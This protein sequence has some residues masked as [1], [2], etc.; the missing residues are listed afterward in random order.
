MGKLVDHQLSDCRIK[1][2]DANDRIAELEARLAQYENGQG[3]DL[4][5]LDTPSPVESLKQLTRKAIQT[6]SKVNGK[7][8]EWYIFEHIDLA[9]KR[10]GQVTLFR[11]DIQELALANIKHG[12]DVAYQDAHDYNKQFTSPFHEYLITL[13]HYEL[14]SQ[15]LAL[16]AQIRETDKHRFLAE[17]EQAGIIDILSGN[18]AGLVAK[19]EK[20]EPSLLPTIL[21]IADDIEDHITAIRRAI[22][23][24]SDG[25]A[26]LIKLAVNGNETNERIMNILA[27]MKK[28]GRP[29]QSTKEH[30]DYI[31]KSNN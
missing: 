31:R 26:M 18:I 2:Q 3:R 19:V 17:L 29:P 22:A 1:L 13:H 16:I 9:L 24:D 5:L 12:M 27:T 23:N 30:T 7:I 20:Y 28:L 8:L 4:A 15:L 11:S 14:T 10:D 21:E 25:G 6:R